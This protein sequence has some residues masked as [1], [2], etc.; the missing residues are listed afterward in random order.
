MPMAR[1]E[2]DARQRHTLTGGAQ[3][4]A[5]QA[6]RKIGAGTGHAAT[7][8]KVCGAPWKAPNGQFGG[9]RKPTGVL[10]LRPIREIGRLRDG[11][12]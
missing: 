12:E 11:E 6:G 2:Q 9:L 8:C 5:A 1:A 4:C 3:P 7:I 10:I